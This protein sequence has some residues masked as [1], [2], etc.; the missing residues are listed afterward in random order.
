MHAGLCVLLAYALWEIYGRGY[1]QLCL[2]LALPAALLLHRSR[3]DPLAGAG[4]RVQ[5]GVW[6]LERQGVRHVIVPGRRSV[7]TR[8]VICLVLSGPAHGAMRR[9]WVFVDAVPAQQWRQLRVQLT[10]LH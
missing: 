1:P 10:L 7:V 2:L 3:H 8:G 9:L 6:T 4:L 5:R